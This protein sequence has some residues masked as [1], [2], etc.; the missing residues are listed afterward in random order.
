MDLHTFEMKMVDYHFAELPGGIYLFKRKHGRWCV[1]NS[2]TDEEKEF[3]SLHDV[4]PYKPA[5]DKTVKELI[6]CLDTMDSRLDGGRG[7]RSGQV[8]KFGHASEGGGPRTDKSDYPARMNVATKTKTPEGAIAAFRKAYGNSEI[9]HGISIGQEGYTNRLV[10]GMAHSVAIGPAR[11]GDLIVH[12][13]PSGICTPSSEDDLLTKRLVEAGGL[14]GIPVVD[15]VII[16][17][18]SYYSY[19]E[20]N[21]ELLKTKQ[22]RIE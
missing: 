16:G 21:E 15:H 20:Q 11:S 1:W 3:G 2:E 9:E 8:Y 22:G 7:A 17:K 5:G 10:H 13:H 14:L 12:N 6:E 19:A 4:L 18:D